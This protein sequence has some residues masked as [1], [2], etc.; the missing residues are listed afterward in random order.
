MECLGII[1]GFEFLIAGIEDD[2]YGFDNFNWIN[3]ISFDIF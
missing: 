2:A 1:V 3:G